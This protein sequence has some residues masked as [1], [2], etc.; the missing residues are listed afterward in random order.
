M[1]RVNVL[2]SILFTIISK[3]AWRSATA[4]DL[5]LINKTLKPVKAMPSATESFISCCAELLDIP[6]RV[7]NIPVSSF[8]SCGGTHLKPIRMPA[9]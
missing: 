1:E 5:S 2:N 3:R 9:P 7:I 6:V 8:G 4:P